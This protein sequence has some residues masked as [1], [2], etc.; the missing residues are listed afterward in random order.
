M[1]DQVFLH[2]PSVV[3]EKLEDVDQ[4]AAEFVDAEFRR[5]VPM[6]GDWAG[7][8]WEDE[9]ASGGTN[10]GRQEQEGADPDPE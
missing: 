9:G 3:W 2:E 5:S 7:V 6:G 8:R 4:G 1:T 10:R